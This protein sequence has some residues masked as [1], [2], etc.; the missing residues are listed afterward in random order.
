MFYNAWMIWL[1]LFI[2]LFIQ[3]I[4]FPAEFWMFKPHWLLLFLLYWVIALPKRVSI[5]SAFVAGL[6]LDLFSGMTLGL[7]SFIYIFIVY[8]IALKAHSIR[9]Y[10]LWQQLIVIFICSL[11]YDILL[12][13]FQAVFLKMIVVSPLIF[14][15]CIGDMLAWIV[16]SFFLG[17]IQKIGAIE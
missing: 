2:G 6:L 4:P 9:N 3:I 1:T 15:S 12:Y 11:F 5:I 7:H 8:F 10:A 14:L 17:F 13:A 16:L